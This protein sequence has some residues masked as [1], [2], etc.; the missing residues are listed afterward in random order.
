MLSATTTTMYYAKKKDEDHRRRILQEAASLDAF[1]VKMSLPER[2]YRQRR[3]VHMHHLSTIS[4]SSSSCHYFI[5]DVVCCSRLFALT[6]HTLSLAF[7][8]FFVQLWAV[9]SFFC[10][11]ISTYSSTYVIR[12][13]V[14]VF[15]LVPQ[16]MHHYVSNTYTC[17][18]FSLN[19]KLAQKAKSTV[20]VRQSWH[21][22]EIQTYCKMLIY[23][24][25]NS[26]GIVRE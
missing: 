6:E 3:M 7:N 17:K 5:S 2:A 25:F 11:L 9:A 19:L 10:F 12:C 24:I 13:R 15:I 16:D 14:V 21:L 22:E 8:S 4:S 26:K 18:A 23:S 1:T 20:C